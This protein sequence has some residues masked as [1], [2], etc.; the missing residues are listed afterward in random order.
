[1][2]TTCIA[3]TADQRVAVSVQ[4]QELRREAF[5]QAVHCL[6]ED[7][8]RFRHVTHVNTDGG[9]DLPVRQRPRQIG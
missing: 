3:V 5:R 8:R 4:E 6:L 1:M 2:Q 9:R 7:F